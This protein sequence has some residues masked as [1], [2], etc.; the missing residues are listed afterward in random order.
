VRVTR[1]AESAALLADTFFDFSN[2]LFVRII[3]KTAVS[4]PPV[5]MNRTIIDLITNRAVCEYYEFFYSYTSRN[6]QNV[7]RFFFIIIC[8]FERIRRL[9]VA[10]DTGFRLKFNIT[11]RQKDASK[12]TRKLE[13]FRH[14]LH[15]LEVEFR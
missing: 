3:F 13:L 15:R 14:S 11:P 7:E 10:R 12:E 6:R 5:F 9:R 1:F 4:S 8:S 2:S